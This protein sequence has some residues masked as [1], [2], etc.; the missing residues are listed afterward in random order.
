MGLPRRTADRC[1]RL[2]ND[3]KGLVPPRVSAAVWKTIWNGWTTGRR[4]QRVGHQCLLCCA[5]QFGEDSIEHYARCAVTIQ[6][7][8]DF[9]GLLDCHPSDRLGNFVTL[10]LNSNRVNDT[11]LVKRAVLVYAIYRTTNSLRHCPANNANVIKDMIHQFARE[12][13]FGHAAAAK[14]LEEWPQGPDV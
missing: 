10:G 7:G 6:A 1:A 8:K 12:A 5:S 4:F 9:V 13:V 14:R 2:L 3:L 11:I